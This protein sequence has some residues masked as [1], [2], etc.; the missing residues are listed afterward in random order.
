MKNILKTIV[1]LFGMSFFFFGCLLTLLSEVLKL[2]EN[3]SVVVIVMFIISLI[4]AIFAFFYCLIHATT[5]KKFSN[6]QKIL[7]AILMLIFR[8]F[9][10]PVYYTFFVIK[11]KKVL[12]ILV[13]AS[14]ILGLFILLMSAFMG[15]VDSDYNDQ[16]Q[17]VITNDSLVEVTLDKNY[18]CDG[19]ECF[20][21]SN[22]I[23]IHNYLNVENR[24]SI[25]EEYYG[26]IIAGLETSDLKVKN[27]EEKDN[28]IVISF[29]QN[30]QKKI[31]E[32]KIYSE[33]LFSIIEFN[34]YIGNEDYYTRVL[35]PNINDSSFNLFM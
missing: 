16:Q 5:N 27:V 19:I 11:I 14:Y 15:E 33:S 28:L 22:D 29:E 35:S 32:L 6:E 13:S 3:L 20:N 10:T 1:V 31:I 26:D 8:Q 23:E 21:N 7:H 4:C 18:I 12:G 34:S 30:S 17:K 25:F 2:P 9:Y 24:D